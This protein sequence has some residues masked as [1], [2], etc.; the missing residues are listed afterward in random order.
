MREAITVKIKMQIVKRHAGDFFVTSERMAA[1]WCNPFR[2]VDLLH[3]KPRVA[4]SSQPWAEV[5]NPFRIAVWQPW[6]EGRD[7]FGIVG[8]G[9]C[10]IGRPDVF[11]TRIGTLN[12]IED[13]DENEEEDE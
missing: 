6:A 3:V 10:L 5:R 11:L 1:R 7:P 8:D 13:E 4:R 12:R 9:K 2:V